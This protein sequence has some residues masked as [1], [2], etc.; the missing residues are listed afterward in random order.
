MGGPRH[1]YEFDVNGLNYDG[2]RNETSDPRPRT[3]TVR[4]RDARPV[5]HR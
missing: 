5:D 3:R 1:N 2:A 4:R